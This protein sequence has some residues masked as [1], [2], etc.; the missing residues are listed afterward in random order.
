MFNRLMGWSI[1]AKANGIMGHNINGALLHQ[2]RQ[3][4]RRATI[5]GKDKESATIRNGPAM[6][7]NAVHCRSHTMFTHTKMDIVASIIISRENAVCAHF[8][9]VGAGQIR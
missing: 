4:D 7:G 1:F 3:S 9:I 2:S 5:I 6:Q 8:G